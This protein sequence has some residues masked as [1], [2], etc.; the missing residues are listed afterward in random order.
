MVAH[1]LIP[2][3]LEGERQEDEKLTLSYKQKG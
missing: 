2:S 3:T 1:A